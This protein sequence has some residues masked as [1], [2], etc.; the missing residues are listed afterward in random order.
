[1]AITTK[2][3]KEAEKL[4]YEVMLR[5]DPSESNS[6][7][8]KKIFSK[9][10][11]IQFEKM[12]K[13]EFPIRFH[14]K[15]FEIEPS[16]GDIKN[17]LDFMNVPM[18]EKVNL[19]HIFINKDGESV[20]SKECMVGYLHIKKM[21][22]FLTK[23]NSMSTNIDQRDMKTGLLINGDRNGKTSDKESES[24]IAIGLNN[25]AKEFNGFKADSINA[26]NIAYNTINN[27]G[28]VSLKDIPY[29]QEDMLSKNLMEVYMIGSMLKSNMITES[30]LLPYYS[31]DR[32][33]SIQRV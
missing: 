25:T 33:K 31:R 28:Q 29:D 5:L 2:Q 27:T 26:K 15:P 14:I 1:M 20:Q 12:F 11:D 21:Q 32:K 18:L 3:R 6:D 4:I 19:P 24:L 30:Y 8:Y 9:M 23:K 13:Q 16:L 7:H 22:Q 17:A 10:S